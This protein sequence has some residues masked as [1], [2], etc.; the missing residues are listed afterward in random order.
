MLRRYL[1]DEIR[2]KKHTGMGDLSDW[3]DFLATGENNEMPRQRN[4]FDCGVFACKFADFL[5]K[6]MPLLFKQEDM[7][8]MRRRITLEL[9]NKQI[10]IDRD[11]AANGGND[12]EEE[13]DENRHTFIFTPFGAFD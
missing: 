1:Q 10:L 2:D 9:L 7:A 12:E 13:E 4:G 6:D 11:R 3:T 5:S 8:Y